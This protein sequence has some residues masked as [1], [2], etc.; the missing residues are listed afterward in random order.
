MRIL[1]FFFGGGA[2]LSYIQFIFTSQ[3]LAK[4]SSTQ[5]VLHAC[6]ALLDQLRPHNSGTWGADSLC[7]IVSMHPCPGPW[8]HTT[9]CTIPCTCHPNWPTFGYLHA[10]FGSSTSTCHLALSSMLD[11]QVRRHVSDLGLCDLSSVQ[12][13]L[14]SSVGGPAVLAMRLWAAAR[15]G[16]G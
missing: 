1:L 12:A 15:L 8:Q 4:L 11:L 2:K 9:G 10:T 16:R 3:A 6:H 5:F 14:D 7:R 13:V